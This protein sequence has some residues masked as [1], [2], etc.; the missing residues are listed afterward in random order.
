MSRPEPARRPGFTLLELLIV[1]GI[2]ALLIVLAVSV[3]AKVTGVGKAKVTEQTLRVLDN[4]LTAYIAEKGAPPGPWVLDPRK[5]G[6]NPNTVYVQPVADARNGT[7]VSPPSGGSSERFIINSV[8]L[9][10][11]QCKAVP[12]ASAALGQLDA[13]YLHDWNPEWSEST[14]WNR[15]PTLLTA[16][17][18]WGQPIR[19]VHPQFK[20]L[21]QQSPT[22]P[23]SFVD[24]TGNTSPLPVTPPLQYGMGMIRRNHVETT[25]N[26]AK[27]S[28]D[29][30][31]GLNASA[32]PYFYSCGPDGD[33]STTADNIYHPAIPRFAKP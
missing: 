3:A 18:G 7:P 24:F 27:E 9:F 20:G 29:S 14:D 5:N 25:F 12:S 8:G 11:L 4:A 28:P 26:G 21:I 1:I 22:D 10:I 33:P 23:M 16:F 13:K 32:R 15:Q 6:G 19:Y 31:A 2:I 17:D 30:D